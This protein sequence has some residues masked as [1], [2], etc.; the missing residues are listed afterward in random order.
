MA[1]QVP[2]VVEKYYIEVSASNRR[3][4][5]TGLF[6]GLGYGVGLTIGTS[7]FFIVLG[8]FVSRVDLQP[9]LGKFLADV[10]KAAQ[11]NLKVK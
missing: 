4:F 6:S 11:P 9:I 3:K 10:I 5:V 7:I 1:H 2:K 8:F